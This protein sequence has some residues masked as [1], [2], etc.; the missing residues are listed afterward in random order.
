MERKLNDEKMYEFFQREAKDIF[1]EFSE[2]PMC[3]MTREG[4]S[5]IYKSLQVIYNIE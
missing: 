1:A 5:K 2:H 3:Q 4:I